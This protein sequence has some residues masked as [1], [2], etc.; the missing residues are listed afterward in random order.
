MA[1]LKNS[2]KNMPV[3]QNDRSS[4]SKLISDQQAGPGAAGHQLSP[5]PPL[6]GP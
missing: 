5:V 3:T 4:C 2:I 1:K 6:L